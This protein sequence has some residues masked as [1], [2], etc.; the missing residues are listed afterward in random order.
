MK[1]SNRPTVSAIYTEK[2]IGDGT[3]KREEAEEIQRQF[4]DQLDRVK[5]FINQSNVH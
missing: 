4:T 3:L 1:I 2:L 5:R